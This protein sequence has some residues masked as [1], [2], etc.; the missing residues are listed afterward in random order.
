MRPPLPCAGAALL[1]GGALLQCGLL[2]AVVAA[3]R[4]LSRFSPAHAADAAVAAD[5]VH[6]QLCQF[7]G[8]CLPCHDAGSLAAGQS[9]IG[10]EP[11]SGRGRG[12]NQ[13]QSSRLCLA[14][15]PVRAVAPDQEEFLLF[16]SFF[17]RLRALAPAV[18]LH[19]LPARHAAPYGPGAPDWPER[20]RRR[21]RHRRV[22]QW[23]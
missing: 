21:A 6:L 4:G 23:L 5:L 7:G 9:G 15:A 20:L 3:G 19:A 16:C 17:G 2:G 12:R 22:H 13:S 8:L 14:G 10:L 1:H 18:G 11:A